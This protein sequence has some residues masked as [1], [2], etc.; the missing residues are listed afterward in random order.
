VSDYASARVTDQRGLYDYAPC[1][2][3]SCTLD[4]TI[5][6]ANETLLALLG[7]ERGE[8]LG[9]SLGA[10]LPPGEALF[11]ETRFVLALRLRSEVREVVLTLTGADGRRVPV[12]VNARVQTR[13][14]G[15][16]F[17]HGAAF[18]I[19][20]RVDYERSLLDARRAAEA[21]EERLR[22]LQEASAHFLTATSLDSLLTTFAATAQDAFAASATAVLLLDE[23]GR[24]SLAAGTHPLGGPLS[25]TKT[26][27]EWDAVR[28]QVPVSVANLEDADSI[29]PGLST[30]MRR[31]RIASL[32]ATPLVGDE[33]A[34]GV[35]VCFFRRND[36]I[37]EST[38]ELQ[39]ALGRQLAQVVHRMQ[40]QEERRRE[41]RTAETLRQRMRQV[42]VRLR[43]ATTPDAMVRLVAQGVGEALGVD[44]VR[45]AVLPEG[46][47]THLDEYWSADATN[48]GASCSEAELRALSTAVWSGE[49]ASGPAGPLEIGT[50]P[51]TPTGDR[52]TEFL[53]GDAHARWIVAPLGDRESV[54][55][56]IAVG[57][58]DPAR[59]WAPIERSLIQNI[60]TDL[61][62][63]LL[64]TSVLIAQDESVRR[65]RQL[66]HE[67]ND[68]LAT[69]NHELRTPLTLITAYVDLI[70][71]HFGER[72]PGKVGHMLDVVERNA[73]WLNSLITRMMASA[74]EGPVSE[75]VQIGNVDVTDLL[76]W[77]M[78]T[79]EP[80]AEMRGVGMLVESPGPLVVQG[81][82]E[83]LGQVLV[84]VIENA[85]KFSV[86]G[87]TVTVRA[88]GPTD[89][90]SSSPVVVTVSDA[91]IG[92]PEADM[93][94]IGTKLFRASNATREAVP[95]TGLGLWIV[96]QILSSSG[97]E[98]ALTSEVGVGTVATI[99]LP[100]VDPRAV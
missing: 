9:A 14:D 54:L 24:L 99:T 41:R 3:F 74:V 69:I 16:P 50:L 38:L 35:V 42:A 7:Y 12:L 31:A 73:S 18:P 79:V 93:S 44:A 13:A 33:G 11:Y 2:L 28:F 71:E 64:L 6:E 62:H 58:N 68:L 84:N 56:I 4:G 96:Q 67:K 20:E 17:V 86:P 94:R 57:T 29:Y 91:G 15:R 65:L 37:R 100:A 48:A 53:G 8:V 52:I 32:T 59:S 39:L 80:A 51:V 21:T 75:Q 95:G 77:V 55:G 83:G 45:I 85:V 82:R 81:D 27:P 72:P 19:D 36:V 1:G 47:L 23:D 98:L 26:A 25:D 63:N 5:V 34:L 97:G 10:L 89:D 60:A 87:G 40:L 61:A 49:G 88:A 90:T 70:K 92:I 46:D 78:Q 30:L 76:E 43:A 66:D 22:V